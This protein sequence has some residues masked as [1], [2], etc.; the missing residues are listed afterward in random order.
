M[1]RALGPS[2]APVRLMHDTIARGVYASV[3]AGLR[4]TGARAAVA[5]TAEL[6]ETPRGAMALAA[7]NGLLGDQL[8]PRA[9]RSRSR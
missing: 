7:L 3:S 5:R 6:S 9:A 1:F 2:A 8:E 4:A